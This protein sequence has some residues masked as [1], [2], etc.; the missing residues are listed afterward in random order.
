MMRGVM[1]PVLTGLLVVGAAWRRPD[2]A[3]GLVV[4]GAVF[5]LI[6]RRWPITPHPF[7]RPGWRTDVVHFLVDQVASGLLLG[8]LV[9]VLVPVFEP[10]LPNLDTLLSGPARLVAALLVGEMTGYWGHRPRLVRPLIAPRFV[11]PTVRTFE[12][13]VDP[14]RPSP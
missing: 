9:T 2:V 10:M 8:L 7:L 14:A 11:T 4:L 12:S 6:E 3:V 1:S 13:F 5:G